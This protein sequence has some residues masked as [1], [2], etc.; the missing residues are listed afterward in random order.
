MKCSKND[1]QRI[2]QHICV[3]IS[4]HRILDDARLLIDRVVEMS[5]YSE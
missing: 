2:V 3:S 4:N 5:R 1:D